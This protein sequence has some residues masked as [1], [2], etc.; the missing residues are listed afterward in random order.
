M[1]VSFL[2]GPCECGVHHLLLPTHCLRVTDMTRTPE[3]HLLPR[4]EEL[5]LSALCTRSY[6]LHTQILADVA[7]ALAD[8][9]QALR[10]VAWLKTTLQQRTMAICPL[11]FEEIV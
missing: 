1:D 6:N 3:T 5:L 7:Q 4:Q 2:R 11:A 9:A 10:D 8:V